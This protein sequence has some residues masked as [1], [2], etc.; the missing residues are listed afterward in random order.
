MRREQ[1]TV[2]FFY[3]RR[4]LIGL[5]PLYNSPAGT[6]GKARTTGNAGTTGKAGTI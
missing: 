6:T 3:K 4:E 5:P 1:L 2:G